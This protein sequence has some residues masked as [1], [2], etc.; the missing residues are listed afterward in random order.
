MHSTITSKPNGRKIRALRRKQGKTQEG[1]LDRSTLSLSTLQRAERGQAIKDFALEEIARLLKTDINDIRAQVIPSEERTARTFR[2]S[3]LSKGQGSKLWDF[4][5][6]DIDHLT[7]VFRVDP[8][9]E[10]ADI[11]ASAVEY[12]DGLLHDIGGFF[13]S[14]D[15][16][17][18]ERIRQIGKLNDHLTTL[19]ELNVCFFAGAYSRWKEVEQKAEIDRS[20]YMEVLSLANPTLENQAEIIVGTVGEDAITEVIKVHCLDTKAA[21]YERCLRSNL[22]LAIPP[23]VIRV[24]AWLDFYKLYTQAFNNKTGDNWRVRL[25]EDENGLLTIAPSNSEPTA[26]ISAAKT[27]DGQK[28]DLEQPA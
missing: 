10:E 11:I 6:N 20:D 13:G 9:G 23:D 28:D 5:T 3:A 1:L 22:K 27:L 8:S 21:V 12:C 18:A 24:R 15:V 4:L 19:R 16:L 14:L 26:L 7:W 25:K 17:P 2:L